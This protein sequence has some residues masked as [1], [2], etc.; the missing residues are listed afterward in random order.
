M[1][2]SQNR[3]SSVEVEAL[4]DCPFSMAEEYAADY[5][6]AAEAGG[7]EATI[8]LGSVRQR[9]TLSFGIH[10]DV[11]EAGRP[12]HEL[13]VKWSAGSQLL[14]DFRGT[15]R[16]RIDELRTRVIVEGTYVPPLGAIGPLFDRLFGRRIATATMQD[17][18]DRIAAYVTKREVRWRTEH[19]MRAAEGSPISGT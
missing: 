11:P 7:S 4:A 14:P 12:H 19:G 3:S 6:R 1:E 5:L 18:A 8:G 17:L 15:F 16:F 2:T 13:R 9:V 10:S